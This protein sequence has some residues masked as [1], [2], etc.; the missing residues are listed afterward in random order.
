MTV[1]S[2]LRRTE[3]EIKYMNRKKA[4]LEITPPVDFWSAL[5]EEVKKDAA[6]YDSQKDLYVTISV[7]LDVT[8]NSDDA[9]TYD[10]KVKVFKT[11]TPEE[12]CAHRN[13]V[14]EIAAKLGHFTHDRNDA[15]QVLD[16][17]GNPMTDNEVANCEA[18][19]LIPLV[20]ST[21]RGNASQV[22]DSYIQKHKTDMVA[23]HL[24]R[25]AWSAVANTIFQHASD[26]AKV[27]RRY[28][29]EGGLKFCGQ[30]REPRKFAE[31]LELVNKYI[32]YFPMSQR[33]GTEVWS[34][35]RPLDDDDLIDVM[36]KARTNVMRTLML[37]SGDHSRKYNE[38]TEYTRVLQDWYNNV[39]LTEALK[40]KDQASQGTTTP[41]KKDS[42]KRRNKNN[43]N[44]SGS[45]RASKRVR[46][47]NEGGNKKPCQHCG[48]THPG[49][50]DKCW[51]LDKNK[52]NRPEWYNSPRKRDNTQSNNNGGKSY[53]KKEF[54]KAVSRAALKA[55]KQIKAQLK[56][57]KKTGKRSRHDDSDDESGTK[58]NYA[59]KTMRDVMNELTDNSDSST[60]SSTQSGDST[61]TSSDASSAESSE[62]ELSTSSD[63]S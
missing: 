2:T 27:Q 13:A 4:E 6:K 58:D 18:K 33:P 42:K 34:R 49:S 59:M 8:D 40:K 17:D 60:L 16:T 43:N 63:D 36:D 11:G 53:N 10:A 22:F 31:R 55:T 14:D 3:G 37:Q 48:K 51:S 19:L 28:L 24:Y 41:S 26:A 9:K 20:Q 12:F 39:E 21:L 47:S 35:P 23:R 7:P 38:F 29:R 5:P 52:S 1:Q 50:D 30:Y 46:F 15:G 61:S 54:N 56:Q 62:D 25:H 44:N 45:E 32:S 57:S